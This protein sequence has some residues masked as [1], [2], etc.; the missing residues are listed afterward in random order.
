MVYVPVD[1]SVI[2]EEV[3]VVVGA[4]EYMALVLW[5]CRIEPYTLSFELCAAR[6]ASR[7]AG[8]QIEENQLARCS[9]EGV[10]V[11]VLSGSPCGL[12]LKS[13]CVVDVMVPV[14]YHNS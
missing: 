2:R 1:G 8:R 14:T 9:V 3:K 10:G 12:F 6:I 13:R 4:P 11:A 7:V 5:R